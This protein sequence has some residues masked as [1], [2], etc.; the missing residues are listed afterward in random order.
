MKI[1]WYFENQYLPAYLYTDTNASK[2]HSYMSQLKLDA[3]I[4]RYIV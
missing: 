4:A 1:Y 3:L 2:A